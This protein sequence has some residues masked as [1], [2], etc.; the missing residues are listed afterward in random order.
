MHDNGTCSLEH[1]LQLDWAIA[2]VPWFNIYFLIESQLCR[3]F[4]KPV[5]DAAT[6]YHAAHHSSAICVFIVRGSR[7]HWRNY[8]DPSLRCRGASDDFRSERTIND[9]DKKCTFARAGRRHSRHKV[10][11]HIDQILFLGL[12]NNAYKK[13]GRIVHANHIIACQRNS[14]AIFGMAASHHCRRR[15]GRVRSAQVI[16]SNFQTKIIINCIHFALAFRCSWFRT[17]IRSMPLQPFK[18]MPFMKPTITCWLWTIFQ[19]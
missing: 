2:H 3:C 17:I 1:I 19:K 6:K 7:V 5:D 12:I 16:S 4:G 11:G 9:L 13:Y 15:Y 10:L 14:A 8:A 18:R